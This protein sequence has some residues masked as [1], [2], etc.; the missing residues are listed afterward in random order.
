MPRL[1]THSLIQ[2]LVA[3]DGEGGADDALGLEME[4]HHALGVP[5]AAALGQA[6]A[7]DDELELIGRTF[8]R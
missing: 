6:R 2:A 4:A 8:R 5:Q 7:E 1:I 3:V